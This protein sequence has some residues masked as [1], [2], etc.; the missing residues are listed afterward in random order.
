MDLVTCLNTRVH[1][2]EQKGFGVYSKEETGKEDGDFALE[3]K[4]ERLLISRFFE[5][6][7]VC[8]V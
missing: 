4:E 8:V 5:I 3:V 1:T 6:W 2:F 7:T